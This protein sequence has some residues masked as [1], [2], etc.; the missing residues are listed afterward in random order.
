MRCAD[1][2]Q[3]STDPMPGALRASLQPGDAG[4]CP[5]SSFRAHSLQLTLLYIRGQSFSTRGA[6]IAAAVRPPASLS[7][8]LPP[9][10]HAKTFTADYSTN[11]RRTLMFTF[12]PA[13]LPFFDYFS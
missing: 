1:G 3:H 2:R 4:E 13:D 9:L 8:N 10:T 7:P 6:F 12:T 5:L 11:P